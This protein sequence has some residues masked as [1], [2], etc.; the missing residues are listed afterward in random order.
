MGSA[1]DLH[2]IALS[3]TR[4]PKFVI[5]GEAYTT[6]ERACPLHTL[7]HT[8]PRR[9]ATPR[10]YGPLY[11]LKPRGASR[12]PLGVGAQYGACRHWLFAC[13][14]CGP[15]PHPPLL[16]YGSRRACRRACRL[17]SHHP[18]HPSI[19]MLLPSILYSCH[20]HRIRRPCRSTT[21][22][23]CARWP[24]LWRTLVT[25]RSSQATLRVAA[26]RRAS[27]CTPHLYF[28]VV[29]LVVKYTAPGE[30][31]TR[32]SAAG[33]RGGRVRPGP[34]AGAPRATQRVSFGRARRV[35]AR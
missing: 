18:F 29:H 33:P 34:P 14:R 1:L 26:S 31:G 9:Q 6:F 19:W 12:L 30:G 10:P 15:P 17:P 5:C 32:A 28:K 2:Y 8:A 27:A 23:Y 13:A 16:P 3:V 22:T 35:G 7:A 25:A 24:P 11:I 4:G 20:R 21:R